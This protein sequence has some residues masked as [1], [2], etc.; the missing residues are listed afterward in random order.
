MVEKR[1]LRKRDRIG[2]LFERNGRATS[3][4]EGLIL[5]HIIKSSATES[6]IERVL[7]RLPV[8]GY[9]VSAIHALK[10]NESHARRA[11]GR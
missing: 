11:A 9:L 5:S 4:A 8:A 6:Q 7:A 1:Q 3:L 10:G 2:R